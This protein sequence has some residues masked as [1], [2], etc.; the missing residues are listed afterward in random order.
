MVKT[1]EE[2]QDLL[3]KEMNR[4]RL[5]MLRYVIGIVVMIGLALW[6]I[7]Y[8]ERNTSSNL[9]LI[10][11]FGYMVYANYRLVK[12]AKT[13]LAYLEELHF[14]DGEIIKYNPGINKTKKWIP[15]EKVEKVYMNI[16]DK[17]NLLF[18]VYRESEDY[19]RA[20]SF[21]KPRIKDEEE[22]MDVI[23][24]RSLLDEEAITFEELKE[25][26]KL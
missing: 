21:Y 22:F 19:R 7:F 6:I 26:I 14:D 11:A 2:Y 3:K 13:Y 25:K 9:L 12:E 15:I 10:V 16:E 17:P 5:V 23:K 24:K 20:E 4:R 1:G 18:V 8:G